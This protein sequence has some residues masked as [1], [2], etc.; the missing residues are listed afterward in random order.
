M[1]LS[2]GGL[3]HMATNGMMARQLDMDS[4]SNIFPIFILP[5][6]NK[7]GSIFRNCSMKMGSVEQPLPAARLVHYRDLCQ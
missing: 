5:D 4:I 2:F 7:A 6:T 3:Y 1:P